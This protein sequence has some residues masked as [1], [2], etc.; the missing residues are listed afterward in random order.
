MAS[1]HLS[2]RLPRETV[3]RLDE[4]SCQSDSTRSE[5]ARTLIEEGLRM[6][7]H[8]GIVFRPGP[9]GRRA[10]LAI[11]P[12]V[13]EIVGAIHNLTGHV[14][15]PVT[16]LGEQICLSTHEIKL[17]LNYYRAFPKEVDRRIALN[18][19]VAAE[20]ET[21]WLREQRLIPT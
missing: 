18:D 5:A 2:I 17:A 19:T 1:Q 3:E 4:L 15:D 16:V 11:G 6:M 8:P 20:L 21:A 7:D 9:T 13:W 14:D 12:D 10:G